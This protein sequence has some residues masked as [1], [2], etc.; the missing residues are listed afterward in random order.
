MN[1]ETPR[2]GETRAGRIDPTRPAT[3]HAPTRLAAKSRYQL[4]G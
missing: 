4:A 2:G 1:P 3:L